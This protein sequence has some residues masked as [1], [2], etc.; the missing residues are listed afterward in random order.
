MGGGWAAIMAKRALSVSRWLGEGGLGGGSIE[1]YEKVVPDCNQ[2]AL[3]TT[4]IYRM[5]WLPFL[6]VVLALAALL[7]WLLCRCVRQKSRLGRL[8]ALAVGMTLLGEA[9][10]SVAWN[11]GFTFLTADF[12]LV[13]GNLHTVLV[14]GLIGLALSVFRG[15]SIAREAPGRTA[16]LPRFSLKISLERN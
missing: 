10:C 15:D 11:L 1:S 14:M 4:L 16:H 7:V 5:G 9:L 12:P 13:M 3:L 6:L 2:S 8:V